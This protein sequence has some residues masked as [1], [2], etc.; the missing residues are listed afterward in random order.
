MR[1]VLEQLGK[2]VLLLSCFVAEELV[3]TVVGRM[4]V[5]LTE[6]FL[7]GVGAGLFRLGRLSRLCLVVAVAA[8]R[9]VLVMFVTAR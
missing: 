7:A 2:F 5:R 1:F 4:R 3:G 9:S 8:L 6:G